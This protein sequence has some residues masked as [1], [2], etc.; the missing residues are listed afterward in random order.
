MAASPRCCPRVSVSIPVSSLPRSALPGG[1]QQGG[2]RAGALVIAPAVLLMD[3]P[4]G[5]LDRQLRKTVQLELRRLHE[6]HRRTT[7]Y[8]THDQEEALVL[9]DRV[10]VMR[11]ARVVQIG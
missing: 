2:A 7:I 4:L 6:A 11:G 8:V 5:A 9:S 1:E 10:A 3:E